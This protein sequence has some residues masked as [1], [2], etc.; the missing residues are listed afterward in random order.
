MKKTPKKKSR[1]VEIFDARIKDDKLSSAGLFELSIL[2]PI[3]SD[4]FHELKRRIELVKALLEVDES[5]QALGIVN[6]LL[7]NP[8]ETRRGA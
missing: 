5:E 4:V 7:K 2:S 6:G 1:T 3:S 8:Q